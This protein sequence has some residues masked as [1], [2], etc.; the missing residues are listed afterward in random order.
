MAQS[1]NPFLG[2]DFFQMMDPAK[3]LEQ[4]RFPGFDPQQAMAAQQ[5]NMEAIAAAN[6]IVFEGAQAVARRQAEILRQTM[7]EASTVMRELSDSG[8]PEDRMTRQAEIAK[9]AFEEAV[10]NMRELAE[11]SAKAQTEAIDQINKRVTES[12]DEIRSQLDEMAKQN[13]QT[14]K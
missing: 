12:L 10:T 11:L 8:A 4:Y 5:K 7:E 14:K 3:L 6:R 1:N 13:K 2:T 9:R